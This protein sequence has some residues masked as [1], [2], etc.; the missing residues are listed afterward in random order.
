MVTHWIKRAVVTIFRL[1]ASDANTRLAQS[2]ILALLVTLMM[3]EVLD[4]V[5][6]VTRSMVSSNWWHRLI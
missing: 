3:L 4:A 2:L 1:I 6:D 5:G